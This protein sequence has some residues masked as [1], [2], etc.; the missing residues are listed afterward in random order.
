M[1]HLFFISFL[2]LYLSA[3]VKRPSTSPEPTLEYK[4]FFAFR[5]RGNSDSAI[6]VLK[7][8]DGDG[9]LFM[10]NTTDGPNLIGT[11]YY[12]D[13]FTGTFKAVYNPVIKDTLRF[14]QTVLQPKDASYKGKSIQGEIYIPVRD[15]RTGDSVKTFKYT[16]FMKDMQGHFTNTV[17]TGSITV[18]F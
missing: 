17:T 6:A 14:T 8:E 3:C 5:V 7:Y 18:D 9:D 13:R 16:F 11:F 10:D 12:L 4:D 1:R 2:A 15:F